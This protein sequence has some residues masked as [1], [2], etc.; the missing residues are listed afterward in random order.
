M[1]TVLTFMFSK[2]AAH[3]FFSVADGIFI[4]MVIPLFYNDNNNNHA[5]Y[6]PVPIH[7]IINKHE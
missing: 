2:I 1:Q 5:L 3:S 4:A 7:K 6:G